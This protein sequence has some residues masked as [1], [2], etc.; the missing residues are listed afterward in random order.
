[1]QDYLKKPNTVVLTDDY[2]PV[3]NLIAPIFEERFGYRRGGSEGQEGEVKRNSYNHSANRA[4]AF[5]DQSL[6]H[7]IFLS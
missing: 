2:V 7:G 1:L 4:A 6:D 3:D 5:I